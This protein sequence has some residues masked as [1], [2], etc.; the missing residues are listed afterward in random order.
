MRV[1]FGIIGLYAGVFAGV[2]ALF[3]LLV[4]S[5]IAD[6]LPLFY[7]GVLFLAVTGIV[8]L[9]A[10]VLFRRRGVRRHGDGAF[11]IESAFAAVVLAVSVNFAFF[12][13][14]PVTIDR[15]VTTFML[16]SMDTEGPTGGAF[17]KGDLRSILVDNFIDLN[18]AVGRRLDEQMLSGNIYRTE[19]GA[20]ALTP[21]A[22]GFLRFAQ[23]VADLYGIPDRYINAAAHAGAN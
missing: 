5:P 8:V 6:G 11:G 19:A 23:G 15:S 13:I 16:S 20:Y 18:D 14:I 17:S 10:A 12:V 1:I 9:A 2:T 7:R 22:E 3:I 21:Q 4:R